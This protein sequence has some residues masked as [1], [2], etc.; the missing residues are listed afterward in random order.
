MRSRFRSLCRS[1][2]VRSSW[3]ALVAL[4]TA[5]CSPDSYTEEERGEDRRQGFH[6]TIG[7]FNSDFIAVV[8]RGLRDPNSFE[9]D[10]TRVGPVQA[11]STHVIAMYFR[12]RNGFGGMNRQV[13]IGS[14]SNATCKVTITMLEQDGR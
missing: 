7:G 12:A 5:A 11:D 8:K 14:M 10:E 13:A 3:L 9:H 6:C 4:S 1:Q 2:P